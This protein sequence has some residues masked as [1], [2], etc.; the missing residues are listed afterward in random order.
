VLR[1]LGIA[2]AA[3]LIAAASVSI[4]AAGVFRARSPATALAF[5]PWDARASAKL[6][7]LSLL[8]PVARRSLDG[9]ADRAR[10]AI[11][12]DPLAIEAVTTLA[13][14]ASLQGREA[15]AGRMF[16]YAQTLSRRAV[17]AQM[18]L[19]EDRVQHDDIRGALTHY[20]IV[21]STSPETRPALMAILIS[22][23]SHPD[24][25]VE[26][27]RM[28]RTGPIWKLDFLTRLA[29][30]GS[31]AGALTAVSRQVLD[32]ALPEER[33]VLARLFM[34]YVALGAY[35]Q[36]WGAY[37]EAMGSVVGDRQSE[38]LLRNGDFARADGL[39]PFD[40]TFP[41]EAALAP[42][43]L[44]RHGANYSFALNLPTSPERDAE[45][46]SQLAR[47]SEGTYE[48]RATTGD[49]APAATGTARPFVRVSCVGEPARELVRAD[50]PPAQSGAGAMYARF[51]VPANCAFQRV[52]IWVRASPDGAPPSAP[53]IS[54]ISLRRL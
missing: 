49:D 10:S 30:L 50:F 25:A 31:D 24:I 52:S 26:V 2:A 4:S 44:P 48:L 34:R 23:V 17:E 16:G 8:D 45:T 14:T 3:L 27:N 15:E 7:Q 40:W 28:L 29:F 42:E 35:D 38:P 41:A 43:R 19:I 6:A 32:P 54:A 37:H 51:A 22:A 33:D 11:R 21:L 12:R 1:S 39:P 13:M 47:L 20:N 5:S 36:A 46:A 53:W 18:W 9:I